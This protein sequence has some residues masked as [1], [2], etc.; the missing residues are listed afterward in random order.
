[1]RIILVLLV[2]INLSNV[3]LG[4]TGK[5]QPSKPNSQ[6][7]SISNEKMVDLP[8]SRRRSK[9]KITLQ[10]ALKL[11][12]GYLKRE[13]IDTSSYYLC[14]VRMIQYGGEKDVKEPHWFLWWTNDRA[15]IGDY[16]EI[17]VSMDGKVGRSPSM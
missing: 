3:V 14:E 8:L 11:A 9:P 1:M 5:D 12:E 16:I 10:E 6:S 15:V 7:Q 17:L 13:K 4:Q 2:L